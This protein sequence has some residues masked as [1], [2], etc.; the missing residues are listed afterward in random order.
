MTYIET[1]ENDELVKYFKIL[2]ND[3]P[4]FIDKYIKTKEMQRLHSIGQFCGCDYTK[5]YSCKYWYSRLDHSIACALMTWHFT[6]DK[7]QTLG[8]LFHDLGTPAFS[9]CIDYLLNDSIKQESSE[10]NI[11]DIISNSKE[12]T[13]LLEEDKININDVTDIGKYTIVENERPKICV[14]RLEGI[15]HTGLVWCHFWQIRDIEEIYNNI[16]VLINEEN[17]QEIG[18]TNISI[19][20]KFYE[21]AYKYSIVLQ[22]NENKFTMQFISGTL[23]KLLDNKIIFLE[24]LYSLSEQE[25]INIIKENDLTSKNW[26]TF[27]NTETIHRE[28]TKPKNKYYVSIECKKRYVI[29][30]IKQENNIIRLNKISKDCEKLL[31]DYLNYNDTKYSYIDL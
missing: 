16:T 23:K 12:I 5:L 28:E 14:D 20:N 30:L 18:F 6:K 15:L 17:E 13:K 9:H 2:S 22:Q 7:K 8:A 25:I 3:Y 10:K 4:N 31:N 19:A 11:T 27:E 21:G 1:L 29:P 26:K 24:N